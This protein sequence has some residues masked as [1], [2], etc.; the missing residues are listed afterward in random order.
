LFHPVNSP[1]NPESL[2]IQSPTPTKRSSLLLWI[3]LPIAFAIFLLRGPLRASSAYANDFAAPYTS[4]SLWL[5]HQNPYNPD[6]FWPTWQSAGAPTGHVY[7]NPSGTHS[8]YPPPSIVVLSPF[9][10]LSWPIASTTLTILSAALYL[11]ALLLLTKA[12]RT[13][14]QP[15]LFII[16]LLFAPT[17][18]AF[19][20]TNVTGLAASLTLIATALL[21]QN[22][23]RHKFAII[24]CL[25]LSISIKHTLAPFILLYLAV[26]RLWT[27]LTATLTLI[28]AATVAF[29]LRQP[30]FNW[31]PSLRSNIDFLFTAGVASLYP[32]NL[33]RTDR[34]D[35]QLPL[36]NLTYSAT[37]AG[38]LAA[39][40][41]IALLILWLR[42]NSKSPG[43]DRQLL[44][45]ATILT[46][47][48]LP[49]Y[50]RF[51]SAI[52]LLIPILWALRNLG[53]PTAHW[54]LTITAI[55]LFNTSVLP[56]RLNLHPNWLL[57]LTLIPHLNWLLLILSL[58]LLGAMKTQNAT[59]P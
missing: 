14:Y 36:F 41:T 58:I 19:H 29:L 32:E 48:L 53:R 23:H 5:H 11:V 49:F 31:L 24:L 43:L 47:G 21:L 30:N 39:A 45:L 28:A 2:T 57:D 26:E 6:L 59:T 44:T 1:K 51:Y 54:T 33:T 12:L 50:Q 4:A 22:P 40:I 9:A 55:F 10:L 46:I 37:A 15:C 16:G 35:I 18:S 25:A 7:S 42:F 34:I 17:L 52:L 3:A 56:R 13:S 8:I 20:V 38:I 27:I